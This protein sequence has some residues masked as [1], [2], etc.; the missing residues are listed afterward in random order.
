MRYICPLPYPD[1]QNSN[2]LQQ[3]NDKYYGCNPQA[4]K[5]NHFSI[6]SKNE[7]RIQSKKNLNCDAQTMTKN[8]K[9]FEFMIP[10]G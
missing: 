1:D 7:F 4:L 6:S 10:N 8:S 3:M 2:S 5:Y 9:C